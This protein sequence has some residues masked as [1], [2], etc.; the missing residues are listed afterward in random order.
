[1]TKN[2]GLKA[3]AKLCLNSLWGKFGQRNNK[4][5]V[6]VVYSVKELWDLLLN[7]QLTDFNISVIDENRLMVAYRLKDV[8]LP[9]SKNTNIYV[10]AFTTSHA[11]LRLYEQLERLGEQVLYHD[12]DSIVYVSR[13]GGY[14]VPTGDMLGEWV[15][16]LDGHDMINTWTSGGPK[17][18]AYQLSDGSSTCKVKG[19]SLKRSDVGSLIHYDAIKKLVEDKYHHNIETKIKTSQSMIT[20]IKPQALLKTVEQS[21]ELRV[22]YT[23]GDV[24]IHENGTVETLPFGYFGK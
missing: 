10:A 20:R 1:M 11:R 24:V 2:P 15:D 5:Q 23:K 18:Y 8:C 7:D 6:D 19:F 13:P 4:T 3:V 17:N 12:T 22:N 21:K 9:N 14:E 16:E